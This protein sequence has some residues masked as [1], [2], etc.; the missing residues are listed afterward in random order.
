MYVLKYIISV[1]RVRSSALSVGEPG[2]RLFAVWSVA[3]YSDPVKRDRMDA[4]LLNG[5]EKFAMRYSRYDRWDISAGLYLQVHK[6]E[7]QRTSILRRLANAYRES[8][9]E[10][11]FLQYTNKALDIALEK[12]AKNPNKI[13]TNL[14]LARA[15]LQLGETDKAVEQGC[16]HTRSL[17][18]EPR[19]SLTA[20]TGPTGWA[21]PT[22]ILKT[23]RQ[24]WSS[25][26]R[27]SD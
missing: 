25:M 15:Y 22:V 21:R 3:L 4:R 7:P 16:A 14:A 1:L 18:R 27:P 2:S 11:R 5:Y 12:Y 13:S 8:G 17:W 10:A 26:K 20:L 23:T 9:D 24:H 19:K 6:I